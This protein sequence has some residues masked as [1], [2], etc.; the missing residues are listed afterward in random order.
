MIGVFL[1]LSARSAAC[2]RAAYYRFICHC[3]KRGA[4]ANHLAGQTSDL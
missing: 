3:E 4:E 1:A 2:K